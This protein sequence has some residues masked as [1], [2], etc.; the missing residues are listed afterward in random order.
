MPFLL[1]R[2]HLSPLCQD[3]RGLAHISWCDSPVGRS[4]RPLSRWGLNLTVFEK[5]RHSTCSKLHFDSCD[6]PA[7]QPSVNSLT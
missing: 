5:R 3:Q 4:A 1:P 7:V 6:I 2:G